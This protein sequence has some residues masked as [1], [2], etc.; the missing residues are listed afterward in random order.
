MYV[1]LL[2]QEGEAAVDED[3]LDD[4]QELFSVFTQVSS[5]MGPMWHGWVREL[6]VC[7]C[8]VYRA[9]AV[10]LLDRHGAVNL[11]AGYV[12]LLSPALCV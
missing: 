5:Y 3:S 12:L 1:A 8:T 9:F 11:P 4:V 10:T 7:E 6:H 2:A